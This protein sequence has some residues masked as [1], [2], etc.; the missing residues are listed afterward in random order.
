MKNNNEKMLITAG[1][2]SDWLIGKAFPRWL[3]CGLDRRYG[4]YVESL[5]M[6]GPRK[7]QGS[8]G[9]E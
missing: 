8:S 3:D 2:M 7:T 1:Q 6:S 4:G 9:R 5:D